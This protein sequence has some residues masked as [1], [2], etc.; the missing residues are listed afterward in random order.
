M[1]VLVLVLVIVVVVILVVLLLVLVSALV[2]VFVSILVLFSSLVGVEVRRRCR[3]PRG[4]DSTGSGK[5]CRRYAQCFVL[6][7]T[8]MRPG[9]HDLTILLHRHAT[10]FHMV[11]LEWIRL[12]PI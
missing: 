6:L 1:L 3:K 10:P 2:F 4:C 7:A 12:D 5:A 9:W 11:N 8:G